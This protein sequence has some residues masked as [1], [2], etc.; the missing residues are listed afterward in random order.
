MRLVPDNLRG[1]VSTTDRAGEMMIWSLSTAVG[2]MVACIGSRSRTLTLSP[3]CSPGWRDYVAGLICNA[4]R[5]EEA[6]QQE[7][8]APGDRYALLAD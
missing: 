2:R 8:A 3:V 5:S 1:R 6:A 4:K 7:Q